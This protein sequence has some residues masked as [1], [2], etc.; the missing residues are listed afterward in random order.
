MVPEDQLQHQHQNQRSSNSSSA[1]CG[2]RSCRKIKQKKIPQRGLGVAQLEK[3]RLEEQQKKEAAAGSSSCF[4]VPLPAD[5]TSPNSHF[6]AGISI[7]NLEIFNPPAAPL[8][9]PLTPYMQR[10]II[11][12]QAASAPLTMIWNGLDFDQHDADGWKVDP[13]F[14]SRSLFH[15]DPMLPSVPLSKKQLPQLQQLSSLVNVSSPS[16][17]GVNLQM[18]PPS[19]QSY[20][21]NSTPLR[22]EEERMV[23]LKRPWPFA[24]EHPPG[25]LT[26]YLRKLPTFAES[27]NTLEEFTGVPD[28]IKFDPSST[29]FRDGPGP[30]SNTVQ[31]EDN[32]DN[33]TK[34]SGAMDGGFLSLAPSTT[35]LISKLKQ[36]ISYSEL[37]S[38]RYQG[39][40]DERLYRIDEWREIQPPQQPFYSFLPAGPTCNAATSNDRKGDG[41]ESVIDL[42]LKL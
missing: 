21:S 42:N 39:S 4:V 23:G 40:M 10:D 15:N 34:Q 26:S 3:I 35:P 32:P 7:P 22:P 30:S 33:Y 14:P 9:A 2:T 38:P 17:S 5:F 24:V 18:E 13:L 6:K 11:T 19:N 29:I 20:C 28:S 16:S 31:L 12:K 27:S 1:G 41:E 25:N 8:P 37:D 36:P